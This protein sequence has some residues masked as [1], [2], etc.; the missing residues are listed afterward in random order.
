MLLYSN[1]GG[2]EWVDQRGFVTGGEEGL[3]CQVEEG[4]AGGGAKG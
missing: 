1:F 4:S 2:G 3:G